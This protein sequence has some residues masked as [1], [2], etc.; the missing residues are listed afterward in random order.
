MAETVAAVPERKKIWGVHPNVFFLG[1][2]SLL[3]DMSSEMIFTLLPLFLSNV[4]GASTAIIGLIGGLSDS[5]EAV[6]RIFSGWLSDKIHRPKLLTVLGYSLAT[7]AKPFMLLASSWAAVTAIRMTDRVGKGIRN[8]PRDALLADSVSGS[9]RGHGFGLRQAM[10]TTGAVLGL[11]L[12][13]V[14]IYSVQGDGPV[15]TRESYRWLVLGGIIPAV[16]SVVVLQIFVQ[17]KRTVKSHS[18]CRQEDSS[19]SCPPTPFS[20]KFKIFLAIIGFFTLGKFSDFFIILR[21][22]NIDVSLIQVVMMLVLFNITYAL[23]AL[24]MGILS[25]KVGRKRLIILGW[26]IYALIYL[27]FA[28]ASSPWHIWLLF[29]GYGLYFGAFEGVGKAFVADL[30]PEDRRG[31]AYGLYNGVT[32]LALLPASLV[33]G[34]LWDSINPSAPFYFGAGIAFLAMLGMVFLVKEPGARPHQ[35]AS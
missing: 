9:K 11:S 6:L 35:S 31:T 3:T 20:L 16:L 22:Q 13:A 29:A 26:S 27:G 33:A 12:A 25:D 10:D 21:A 1:L 28:L 32:S 23:S 7:V 18:T 2:T 30:A 17:E 19:S 4:L 5:T 8:S 34:W 14:I 15:L 24:P